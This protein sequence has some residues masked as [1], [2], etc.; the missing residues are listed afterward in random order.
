MESFHDQKK[1]TPLHSGGWSLIRAFYVIQTTATSLLLTNA[2]FLIL[3]KLVTQVTGALWTRAGVTAKMGT[4]TI[5]GLT[6][7]HD[8]HLYPW[9]ADR[10]AA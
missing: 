6:A 3:I 1:S 8:L 7:I 10:Q 9:K 2:S 4:S 5:V